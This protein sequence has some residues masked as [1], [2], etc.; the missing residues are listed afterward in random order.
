MN[1]PKFRPLKFG[2]TRVNLQSGEPGTQYLKADQ[3][4]QAFPD[5]LTDRLQH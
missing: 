3:D 1:A 5:R 2:V 4:L